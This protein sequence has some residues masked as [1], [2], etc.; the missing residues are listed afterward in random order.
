MQ[1]KDGS[2]IMKVKLPRAKK[3]KIPKA[4]KI[5]IPK[6][7]KIRIPKAMKRKVPK[8]M[9][10]KRPNAAL[11]FIAYALVYPV[12]KV[13]FRLKVDRKDLDLPKGPHII[14]SNHLTMYD[15]LLV[16]LPLYPHRLNAVT[17]QKFFLYRPLHKLLPIVGCI[18]KNMFDADIRSVISMKSVLKDGNGVLLFPE[19][20]CSSNHEYMGMHKAT[21]KLIKKLGAP[22]IS[23]YMEGAA[24]CMAHWRKGVRYGR[25][26][27]TYKNLFSTDD[28][29]SMSVEE[30]NSAIDARLSGAEGA[31]PPDKPF[32]TF[33]ARRLAEGLHQVLYYCPKCGQDFTMTT[34]GNMIRCSQCGN[35]AIMDCEAGLTPTDGSIAHEEISL[36][37]RDQVRHEMSS[38]SEDMEPIIEKV[39]V[40]TPSPKPGDGMIESGYG[41]MRLDP[42]G[43]HFDGVLSGKDV[44]LFFPVE[45]VPVISY[46]HSDNFQIYSGGS[47]FQFVPED[48]RKSIK[49]FILAECMHW[50]FSS[51]IVMT[52]GVNSGFV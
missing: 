21:G 28:I 40:R 37:Y 50:K 19:G 38:L 34:K 49:Y 18:P 32:R 11:Y 44:S 25:I 27:V 41:T 17:A 8:A 31:P 29:A 39:K 6:A 4:V 47:Y 13:C 33:G 7:V 16:M 2:A 14:L 23:C 45:T 24:T 43:W 10:A 51:R 36:W 26:Q 42:R 5:K 30:I 12:L 3:V 48:P 22:V 15:F 46:D 1:K 9:R 35:A 52:P 20:R